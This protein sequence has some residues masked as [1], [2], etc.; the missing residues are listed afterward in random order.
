MSPT[1]LSRRAILAGAAS[2]PA[3]TALPAEAAD[4]PDAELLA[5]GSQLE[6]I[7]REWVVKRASDGPER[8]AWQAACERAGFPQIAFGSVP[9]DEWRAYQDK[10]G[11]I[12]PD[13][14][15]EKELDE[16]GASVVW[17]SI[18]ERLEPLVEDILAYEAQTVAGLAIQARAMSVWHA[19]LWDTGVYDEADDHRVF[20]EAVCSFAGVQ[21]VPLTEAVQS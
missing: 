14:E 11:H 9:D 3:L 6:P 19:D 15:E 10:R 4:N 21:P 7:I 17:N 13:D 5:L 20:I 8:A 18:H 16:H 12:R 1:N 2:V